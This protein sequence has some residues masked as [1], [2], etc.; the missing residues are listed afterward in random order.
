MQEFLR[1]DGKL[2]RELVHDFFGVAVND[3]SDGVLKGDTPL[4][5]VEKLVL[6]DFGGRCLVFDGRRGVGDDHVGES[7]RAAFIAQEE[8]VA[9]AVITRVLGMDTHLH[10]SPVGVL[11]MACGDTFGDDTRA[12]VFADV[13]HLRSG[14]CLLVVIGEGYGVEL[15]R[16]VIAAED[17]GGVFPSD[18][19]ACLD[20]CP[21]EAKRGVRSRG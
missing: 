12:G 13:N 9:L 19:R 18:G 1:L 14:V 17:A 6:V 3:E 10:E 5:A 7:V 16:G 15:R 8:R 20:L 11:A 21:R 4:L 2:H